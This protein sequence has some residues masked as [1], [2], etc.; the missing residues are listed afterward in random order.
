MRLKKKTRQGVPRRQTNRRKKNMTRIRRKTAYDRR[1]AFR[2]ARE[3]GVSLSWNR[4][5]NML[6]QDGFAR[7]GL[8]CFD[9]L[10][11]PCRINPFARAEERTVCGFAPDDLVY[12]TIMRLLGASAIEGD[13]YHSIVAAARAA[14]TPYLQKQEGDYLIGPGTL[15]IHKPNVVSE[16]PDREQFAQLSGAGINV[17]TAGSLV[18]GYGCASAFSEAEFLLLT[19]LVDVYVTYPHGIGIPRGAAG[20]LHTTVTGCED[21]GA[22]ISA[23]KDAFARRGNISPDPFTENIQTVPMRRA[24]EQAGDQA[25]V[26][27]GEGNLKFTT[28]ELALNSITAFRDGGRAV[29]ACGGTAIALAKYGLKDLIWCSEDASAL[30]HCDCGEFKPVVLLPELYRR[31]G[32]AEAVALGAAG[33]RVFTASELPL[34]NSPLGRQLGTLVRYAEPETYIEAVKEERGYA[35]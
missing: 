15:D 4:Y 26:I 8:S 6:P 31:N 2:R 29:I 13:H 1:P 10:L 35:N 11:G 18:P 27:G 22:V 3:A 17:V 34:G 33:F 19:G 30:L 25:V 23:A 21:T 16:V 7:L 32:I 12:R 20:P 9:C 14:L 28:D 5:E 24:L